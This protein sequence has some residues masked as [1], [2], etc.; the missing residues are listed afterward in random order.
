MCLTRAQIRE[1]D[2]VP[3]LVLTH[4]WEAQQLCPPSLP[5]QADLMS[6]PLPLGLSHFSSLKPDLPQGNPGPDVGPQEVKR[7]ESYWVHG[8]CQIFTI[9]VCR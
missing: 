1:Q 8:C 7:R 9:C 4:L 3:C 2:A 5:P 6:L